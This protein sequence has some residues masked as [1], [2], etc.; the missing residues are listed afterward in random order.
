MKKYNI[1]E[2]MDHEENLRRQI[3]RLDNEM[4][5]LVYENYNKFINATQTVKKASFFHFLMHSLKQ[6]MIENSR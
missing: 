2:L 5:T 3:Q 1:S 6:S 4:Q